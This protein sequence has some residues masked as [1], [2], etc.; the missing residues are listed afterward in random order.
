LTDPQLAHRGALATVRD[1]A[2]SFLV[3]NAP[4]RLSGGPVRAGAEVPELGAD[5]PLVHAALAR[6]PATDAWP[7][8]GRPEERAEGAE[9]AADANH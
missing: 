3:P 6:D 8:P 4:F 1:S 7:S 2:G 5:G 9:G